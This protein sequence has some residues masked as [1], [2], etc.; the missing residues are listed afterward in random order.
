VTDHGVSLTGVYQGR[1][2]MT[3]TYPTLNAARQVL[4]LVT[5]ED[6]VDALR[7]LRAGDTSIPGG[8]VAAA[9]QLIIADAAA[10]GA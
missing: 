7:R 6:K 9:S 3:L 2:R 1:I 4:W 10:A 8:R 5:G